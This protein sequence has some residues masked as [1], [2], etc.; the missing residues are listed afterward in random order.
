[1]PFSTAL[2]VI[3]CNVDLSG[4]W[5]LNFEGKNCFPLSINI[6]STV[7]LPD[8]FTFYQSMEAPSLAYLS[9]YHVFS[10]NY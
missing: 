2:A 7:G 6:L 4:H 9:S 5:S 1:M 3:I 8:A 10:W